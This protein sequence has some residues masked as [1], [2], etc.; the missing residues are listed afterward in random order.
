MNL[1]D[2]LDTKQ[3]ADWSSGL[4]LIQPQLKLQA[5]PPIKKPNVRKYFSK[6]LTGNFTQF[7][8]FVHKCVT[9]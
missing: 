6:Y 8:Y 3:I 1:Y 5:K 7:S 4:K 9:F 2:D